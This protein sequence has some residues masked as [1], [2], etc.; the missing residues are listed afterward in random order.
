[1][2]FVRGFCL[3]FSAFLS[4]TQQSMEFLVPPGLF[5]ELLFQQFDSLSRGSQLAL[6]GCS[7]IGKV[8]LFL[9]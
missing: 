3:C 4:L 1:M 7:D 8:T 2:G 9:L 5:I 6:L